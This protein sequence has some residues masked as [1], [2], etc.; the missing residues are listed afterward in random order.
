M[1]LEDI[2]DAHGDPYIMYDN[3]VETGFGTGLYRDKNNK[4][5][6]RL[7][8]RTST[9]YSAVSFAAINIFF[10]HYPNITQNIVARRDV[11][12]VTF[13]LTST[14]TFTLDSSVAYE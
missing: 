13:L 2:R 6:V 12:E 4:W 10:L 5:A 9:F 7:F 3:F 8:F 1:V 14:S 11:D